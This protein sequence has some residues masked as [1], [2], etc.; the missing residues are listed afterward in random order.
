MVGLELTFD[1]QDFIVSKTDLS[2]KIIYCNEVFI[3]ISEYSEAE[4]L[5]Q[6]HSILR[7]PEMP[8]SIFKFLWT[9]IKRKEEIF[10]YVVNKT[11]YHNYYWV[12][13]HITP[14]LNDQEQIIGYHSVRRKPT[15]KALDVIKPLYRQLLDAEKIGGI[16]A[17]EKLLETFLQKQKRSYDEFILSL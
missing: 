16:H 7:H 13:A 2:G 14:S 6:P 9:K 8:A 4:L 5:N 15:Q 10:S 11:K 1:D 3:N 17:G 12:M